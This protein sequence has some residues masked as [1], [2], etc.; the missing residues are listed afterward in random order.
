M[1]LWTIPFGLA[2]V[3][4]ASVSS[5][6][7][8]SVAAGESIQ[9]AIG[10][11][12]A[13]D[14]IELAAVTFSEDLTLS[15]SGASGMPI[16]IQGQS[17]SVLQGAIEL[18]GD[19]WVIRDLKIEA[20]GGGD[21]IQISGSNNSILAIDLVGSGSDD[22]DGIDGGGTHNEVRGSSIHGFV[23][24][25]PTAISDAHCIVLNPGA[26]DWLIVENQLYDCSGDGVQLYASTA[27][28]DIK[29]TRIEKNVIYWSGAIGLMENAVDVKNADGLHIIGNTM[30]GF[31]GNKTL[32]FQKGPANVEVS[33]NVMY[34]G[35]T[36]VEF[37]AEDGGTVENVTFSRNL[38]HDFTDYAL[39]FDGTL[40]A[41]VFNNTF[42][43]AAKD[44]LRIEGAGLTG[45]AVQNNLWV[46][47][48][49][50]DTG[51]FTADH[52]GYFNAATDIGSAS[53]VT[54]DPLLDAS[55]QL[56][57][58]SPMIDKGVDVGLPFE[59]SAPDIGFSEVGNPDP[60]VAA[61]A[62]TG[63]TPGT[64]GV[65]G[66]GGSQTGG[67][68]S[69]GAG[70]AGG[71]AGSPSGAADSGDDGS[72]GCRVPGG[73]RTPAGAFTLLLALAALAT[74]RRGFL[75]R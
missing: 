4:A 28:R 31:T 5:A 1:R 71:G 38:M 58:G 33:C 52:N 6:K 49:S 69:G 50:V 29:N 59:G 37:R 3:C 17:G 57:S 10:S 32:V 14:V 16:T 27:A 23:G 25:S 26:E 55:F 47:T 41:N 70:N 15:S 2:L 72:C 39:K 46:D 40:N 66:T 68:S 51:A 36:G 20:Q 67:T 53:D 7:T 48:G 75:R 22:G 74:S 21:A 8:I 54:G 34:S 62:G 24:G 61:S 9:A 30:Y 63:G 12:V 60:C 45:G 73:G 18:D 13:G 11:A 42:K 44:G 64:G 19:Y 35:F 65:P 56:T 43:T